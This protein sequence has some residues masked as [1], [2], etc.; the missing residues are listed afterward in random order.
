LTTYDNLRKYLPELA[1]I[2]SEREEEVKDIFLTFEQ[3]LKPGLN[4][5]SLKYPLSFA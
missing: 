4:D 3:M 2:G 1:L 5:N